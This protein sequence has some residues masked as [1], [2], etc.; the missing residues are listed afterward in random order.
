MRRRRRHFLQSLHVTVKSGKMRVISKRTEFKIVDTIRRFHEELETNCNE[1]YSRYLNLVNPYCQQSYWQLLRK[2]YQQP[3]S[4]A[5]FAAISEMNWTN[6]RSSCANQGNIEIKKCGPN[7]L[8]TDVQSKVII[9]GE[10]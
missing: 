8:G 5:H 6:L 3:S 1:L 9:I 10:V 4:I 7:R 2:C